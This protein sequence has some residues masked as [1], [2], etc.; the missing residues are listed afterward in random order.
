[1]FG[2]I[3]N[4]TD[5]AREGQLV[6]VEPNVVSQQMNQYQKTKN[7]VSVNSL[8]AKPMVPLW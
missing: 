8:G 7:S 4:L 3:S 2:C 5:S 6:I 1:M